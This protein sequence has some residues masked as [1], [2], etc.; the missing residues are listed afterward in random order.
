MSPFI[1]SV[2]FTIGIAGLFLLDRGEKNQVSKSLW[3]PTAWLFFCLSRSASQWLGL[4]PPADLAAS[5]VEGSPV[6]AAV[7]EAIEVLALIVVVSRRRLVFQ[8]LQKNWAILLFFSYAVL[9]ICWSDYPFVTVKHLIKGIGDLMMVL[10]VLTEPNVP[11]AIKTLFTRLSFVLLP[12]SILFIKYYPQLGR[13]LDLSWKLEPVGVALQKNSLGELC[14]VLGLALFWRL[15]SAY[16]DR[17]TLRRLGRMAALAAPLLMAMWMLWM[18]DSLTSICALSMAA[19]VM[20]LSTW[21]VFHRRPAL[22]HILIAALLAV[23]TFALFFQSSGGLIQ[24]LGRNPTLTGRTDIWKAVLSIPNNRLVGVGY[25]SF[26]MGSRLQELWYWFPGLKLQEAHDG[27]LE[28]F[29][30]LGWIGV[31]LF[32]ILIVT[33]YRNAIRAYRLDPDLG[34]LRLA[35]FLAAIITGFTEAAFRMMGP[36][37]VV[38]LLAI[39]ATPVYLAPKVGHRKRKGKQPAKPAWD[40]STVEEEAPVA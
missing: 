12:L 8:V 24:G 32:G 25:E 11:D 20:F 29:I 40:P 10:I 27:Y 23:T 6:D 16:K 17:G 1:A 18:C 13:L 37:W 7:L 19:T 22:M 15:C 33:G 39:T 31:F 35:L 34:G 4:S 5:Y 28:I 36:L 21:S 3:I 30:N 38:F 2:I 9:S 26:W 14:D